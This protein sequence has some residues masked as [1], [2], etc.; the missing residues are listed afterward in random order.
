MN[1]GNW[2]SALFKSLFT[3]SLLIPIVYLTESFQLNSFELSGLFGLFVSF[4]L[5]I[6]VFLLFS[7]VGWS[8]IG[9]P[10]HWLACKFNCTNCFYYAL[11]PA[12]FL[13]VSYF[14][15]G[16]WLLGLIALTEALLFRYFVFKI[17]T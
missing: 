11:V 6:G 9:F 4:L 13:C 10:I 16:P 15:N 3:S 8:F 12:S 2:D 5:Y 7:L 14:T 17:K 1:S